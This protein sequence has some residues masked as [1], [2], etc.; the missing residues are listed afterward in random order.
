MTSLSPAAARPLRVAHLTATFPPYPGGAGNTAHRFAVGQAERGH[1]VEVFTAPASGTAPGSPGVEVHRVKPVFAIGNAPFLPG[2][3]RLGGFDVVHLHYPFI[4]GAD[5]TLFARLRRARRSQALLVHYKNR[6]V[7]DAGRGLLFETYEHTVAPALIRAADRVCVLSADH[8]QSVSY[9][10]KT[11]ERDPAKLIEMPNGVD[12]ERFSPGEDASGLRQRLGIPA[13]AVV[14]AFVATLD[15]AHHFKRLD[16]AIDA[17]AELGGGDTHIV[18]AGGG[19]LIGSFREHARERGVDE[20]VHFL[21]A[22]PHSELPNVLR[23]SDL[24]LLTTEPPESFGIV[25]IE[26]MATGL[27]VIATDYPGVRAVV[28]EGTGLLAPRGDV[29]GVAARLRELAEMGPEGRRAMGSRGRARAL[30][31][32]NWPHLLDRMDDAYAEA[33]AARAAKMA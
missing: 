12:A 18:V 26:A 22:V 20:R 9:L 13:D 33:I 11:G 28:A 25:L 23:A 16:V 17:L 4:F 29:S 1:H 32:W 3:A 7:G 5:L 31:E 19:E 14:A 30:A 2:L 27:P 21:G 10:R 6:L 8:A 15:R 24:F